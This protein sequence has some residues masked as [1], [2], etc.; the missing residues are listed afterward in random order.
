[1]EDDIVT[2]ELNALIKK[3]HEASV[4]L[5]Q[6]QPYLPKWKHSQDNVQEVQEFAREIITVTSSKLEKLLRPP[7]KSVQIVADADLFYEGRHDKVLFP[8]T[9]DWFEEMGFKRYNAPYT[10][11]DNWDKQYIY[12]TYLIPD[13]IEKDQKV[14][15]MWFFHGGGFVSTFA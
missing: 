5:K 6:E 2:D 8:R 7:G 14:P 15:L 12:A 11:A 4:K 3:L 13:T 1:M 9:K 10:Y